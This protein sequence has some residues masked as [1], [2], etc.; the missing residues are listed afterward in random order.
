MPGPSRV[1]TCPGAEVRRPHR[2]VTRYI[3]RWVGAVRAGC[4]YTVAARC[5][6]TGSRATAP[7]HD[8]GDGRCG[9]SGARAARGRGHRRLAQGASH[10]HAVS[11]KDTRTVRAAAGGGRRAARAREGVWVR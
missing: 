10:R 3:G 6:L 4:G 7:G 8:G 9:A 11:P 5:T 1:S 2:G